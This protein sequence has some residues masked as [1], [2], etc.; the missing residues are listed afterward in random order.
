M[1]TDRIEPVALS[2]M[3][4]QA[5]ITAQDCVDQR[6]SFSYMDIAAASVKDYINACRVP[7]QLSTQVRG[8]YENEVLRYLLAEG[9]RRS[10]P[11][12]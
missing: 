9:A 5:V 3:Q 11:T 1:R 10:W 4:R 6:I 2:V 8:E 7:F 12:R